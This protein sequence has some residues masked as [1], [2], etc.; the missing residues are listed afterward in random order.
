MGG[1]G[2]FLRVPPPN[3][4][5]L[6]SA[7]RRATHDET[8]F[9]ATIPPPPPSTS[10][11]REKKETP[12]T[13]QGKQPNSSTDLPTFLRSGACLFLFYPSLLPSL[14]R[15]ATHCIAMHCCPQ[16]KPAAVSLLLLFLSSSLP[17]TNHIFAGLQCT[18]RPAPPPPTGPL[19]HRSSVGE[20]RW[21]ETAAARGTSWPFQRLILPSS[22]DRRGRR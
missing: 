10:N 18:T 7:P 8:R 19:G 22:G 12:A 6:R 1:A 5:S 21:W 2:F 4:L 3:T 9:R 14:D 16:P 20:E 11:K 15:N 13:A 17:T